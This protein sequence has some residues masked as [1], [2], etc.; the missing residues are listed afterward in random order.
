M[1]PLGGLPTRGERSIERGERVLA[2]A[3]AQL[4]DRLGR[5]ADGPTAHHA[6][7]SSADEAPPL[8]SSGPWVAGTQHASIADLSLA[9]EIASMQALGDFE[10]RMLKVPRVSDW[11]GRFE[12]FAGEEWVESCRLL[13]KVCQLARDKGIDRPS[14]GAS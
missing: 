2:R 12:T 10:E 3:L 8:E 1:G 14:Q 4:E 9:S 7:Q 5:L 13:K 6:L 11:F